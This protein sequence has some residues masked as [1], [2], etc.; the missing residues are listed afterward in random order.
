MALAQYIRGNQGVGSS[1]LPFFLKDVKGSAPAILQT[2]KNVIL[3]DFLKGFKQVNSNIPQL[4]SMTK[5][6]LRTLLNQ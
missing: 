1:S 6:Q 5:E 3:S 4:K 2:N